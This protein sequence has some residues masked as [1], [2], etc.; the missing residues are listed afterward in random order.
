MADLLVFIDGAF[1]GEAV[2]AGR[3]HA[4]FRYD[5]SYLS[6]QFATPLSLQAPLGRQPHQI[7]TWLDGL[8]PDNPA[9]RRLWADRNQAASTSPADLLATPVG[10]DCAGSVQF[11]PSGEER[12]LPSRDSGV[13]WLSED[14]IGEWVRSARDDWD[15]WHGLG[16][17]GQFSL[18][19]AQAKCAL[20]RDGESWGAPYGD[21][22][23]T[24]ILKPGLHG[25]EAAEVVEHVCLQAAR[26]LG[27]AAAASEVCR[28][29]GERVIAVERFDRS[30][31]EGGWRRLHQED[32]CQ[33]LGVAP[34]DKY[35]SDGGPSP[36]DVF[37][38]LDRESADRRSDAARFMDALIYN[39]AIAGTDAHA[40]NY[41]LSLDSGLVTLAPLY[42]V[43]SV[44]PWSQ[45]VPHWKQRTAM[46]IGRDYTLRKADSKSAWVRLALSVGQDPA[47]TLQRAEDILQRVPEA[48]AAAIDLLDPAD[49]ASA[50]IHSLER[51]VKRRSA[52]VLEWLASEPTPGPR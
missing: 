28:F 16:E 44:L 22:P 47:A 33:A 42:D 17:H 23:T 32:L 49:R 3:A 40:K 30:H 13:Q 46:K 27:I 9:V 50:E 25:M 11:L 31:G 10:L 18:G 20:R 12:S 8:L 43:I 15:R 52:E 48:I 2:S 5:D 35:Q 39:W 14:E 34:D 51:L 21:A 38:L 7:G 45:G 41:S 36:A 29:D 6:R 4:E 1:A 37:G 26:R 19:G 24:H